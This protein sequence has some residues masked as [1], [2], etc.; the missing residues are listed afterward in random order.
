MIEHKKWRHEGNPQEKILF[1]KFMEYFL[2]QPSRRDLAGII[3]GWHSSS[4]S[5]PN[6]YLTEREEIICTN[7]IQWLGSPIG[8]NFLRECGFELKQK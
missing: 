5:V 8:M 2:T 1:D 3:F 4:Q 7:M 6:D